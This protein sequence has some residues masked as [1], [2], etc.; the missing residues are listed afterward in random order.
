MPESP[1]H[2]T[3]H[4]LNEAAVLAEEL[5]AQLPD[6]QQSQGHTVA[7]ALL[8]ATALIEEMQ[9]RLRVAEGTLNQLAS[10]AMRTASDVSPS[11]L[12]LWPPL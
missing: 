7:R 12:G 1:T 6:D 11:S 3:L 5:V 2:F 4:N 9:R 8:Y 10:T